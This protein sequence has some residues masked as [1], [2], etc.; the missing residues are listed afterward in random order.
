MELDLTVVLLLDAVVERRVNDLQPRRE[1]A[2]AVDSRGLGDVD[3][4]SPAQRGGVLVGLHG[5]C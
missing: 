1:V 2:V 5:E 3:D 4:D